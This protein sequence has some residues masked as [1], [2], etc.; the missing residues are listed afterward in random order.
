MEVVILASIADCL[1][2][3]ILLGL[4]LYVVLRDPNN[5]KDS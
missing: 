4:A 5:N 2:T 1:L 3:F